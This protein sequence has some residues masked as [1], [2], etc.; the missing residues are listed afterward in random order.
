MLSIIKSV[1]ENQRAL[2]EESM[3]TVKEVLEKHGLNDK[4]PAELSWMGRH[5]NFSYPRL[6]G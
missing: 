4:T 2:A 6:W 1:T 5:I 3:G